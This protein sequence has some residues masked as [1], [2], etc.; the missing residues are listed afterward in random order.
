MPYAVLFPGQ[1]SQFVGMGADLFEA[2][3]DLVGEPADEMLGFSLRTIC[4]EGPEDV[5][6]RTEHAQPALYALAYALWEELAPHVPAP[7]AAAGHSLGEYTALAAA[8]VF[9]YR[10]GLGLVAER[11]RA[12]ADAADAEPSTM[13]AVIGSGLADVERVCRRRRDEGGQLWVANINDPGQIVVAGGIE[14]VD[15][16][17][18]SA[19]DLGLR[20]VVPLSVAGAFHSPYMASAAEHLT[21]A[22]GDFDPAAPRFPVYS[23]VTARPIKAAGVS[24][25]LAEQVTA[26]V[27]FSESLGAM[28]DAGIDTFVH[29][30][31]GYMTAGLAKRTI[32]GAKVITVST[33]GD[34][35]AASEALGSMPLP[36]RR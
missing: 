17:A 15:W 34:V 2:R 36:A 27:R 30:G 18:G 5:L 26:P 14:D 11:G 31:P 16:L 24:E 25:S 13:A 4:L 28:A 3:P 21:R 1:G 6:T 32:K 35:A 9:S 22:L 12:M 20:R 8:G 29:V 23:N 7:A 33:L 19:R 10:E